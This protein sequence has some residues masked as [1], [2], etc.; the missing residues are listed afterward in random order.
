MPTTKSRLNR[1]AEY[2]DSPR[3]DQRMKRATQISARAHG[4]L[5]LYRVHA[6]LK[7]RDD[8]G[9]TCPS[10]YRPCKHV[11]AMKATYAK[12]PRTFVDI[13]KKLGK[14]KTMSAPELM[15]LIEKI[16]AE[17]PEALASMGARGFSRMSRWTD[18]EY[19]EEAPDE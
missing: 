15:K 8:C 9:C 13:D 10:E 4:T 6:D 16:V 7:D 12:R 3:L 17:H 11:A 14:R 2:V 5:G 18:A 19:K 1:V